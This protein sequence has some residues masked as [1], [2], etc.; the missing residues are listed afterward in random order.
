MRCWWN[1]YNIFVCVRS[2]D[3]LNTQHV[4][5]CVKW[6]SK[7]EPIYTRIIDLFIYLEDSSKMRFKSNSAGENMMSKCDAYTTKVLRTPFALSLPSFFIRFNNN[8]WHFCGMNKSIEQKT[9]TPQHMVFLEW[10][11]A[12][13]S[14]RNV[15]NSIHFVFLP[16]SSTKSI[17]YTNGAAHETIQKC[18]NFVQ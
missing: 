6:E 14:F 4:W 18:K 12:C 1:M 17:K 10:L 2:F 8:C 9:R 15:N 7:T 16:N 11:L 5:N 3:N 13:A